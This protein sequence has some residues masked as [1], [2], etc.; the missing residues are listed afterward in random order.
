MIRAVHLHAPD[1]PGGHG[2]DVGEVPPRLPAHPAGPARADAR[3]NQ[4]AGTRPLDR[5]RKGYRVAW[6]MGRGLTLLGVDDLPG[7]EY[8]GRE[9]LA[10]ILR[11][12][13]E[14]LMVLIGDDHVAVVELDLVARAAVHH[15]GRREHLRGLT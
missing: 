5:G 7:R 11:I 14:P 8:P 12:P 3:G 13:G 6:P 2:P 4:Q 9:K 15:L 10:K 1:W